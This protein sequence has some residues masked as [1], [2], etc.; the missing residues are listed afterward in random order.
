[1]ESEDD[2]ED[3]KLAKENAKKKTPWAVFDLKRDDEEAV[4]A[5][6]LADIDEDGFQQSTFKSSRGDRAGAEKA[7]SSSVG[8]ASAHDDAIFGG[9]VKTEKPSEDRASSVKEEPPAKPLSIIE[10]VFEVK[11]P[12][13]MA[14][15][16]LK[17]LLAHPSLYEDPKIKDARW[18]KKWLE[19][20][21][22]K[23]EEMK[24]G[25]VNG[26]PSVGISIY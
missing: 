18:K 21:R 12:D 1:M 8:G 20:R 10:K 3:T 17:G 15:V 5:K 26:A 23:L 2:D 25:G 14:G 13:N 24:K 7:G 11:L 22:K 9:K 16:D 4:R 19:M 6:Q